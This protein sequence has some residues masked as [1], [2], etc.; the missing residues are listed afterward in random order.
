[1]KKAIFGLGI[2]ST[3]LLS[4][5]GC[6]NDLDEINR[7]FSK[8]EIEVEIAKTVEILYSDSAVTR[9]KVVAPVMKRYTDKTNPKEEFPNGLKVDFYDMDKKVTS[10]LTAKYGERYQQQGI[11]IV[12]DSVVWKSSTKE[13]LETSELTWDEK[14]EKVYTNKFVVVRRP[15]EILYGYGFESNQ[16]FTRSKI[17][18][19]E[20][21]LKVDDFE[22]DFQD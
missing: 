10:W 3:I 5:L 14:K 19:I 1:M 7:L 11:I 15:G 9:V 4:A 17:R 18:A 22:K 12:R 2:I 20:G 13:Q 21:R 8:D 16:D 6:E